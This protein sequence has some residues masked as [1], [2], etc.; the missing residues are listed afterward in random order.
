MLRG[1][2]KEK[3]EMEWRMYNKVSFARLTHSFMLANKWSGV[4][5]PSAGYALIL[6]MRA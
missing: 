4:Y 2:G 5:F 3:N 6:D 1:D